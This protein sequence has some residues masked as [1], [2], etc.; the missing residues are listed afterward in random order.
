VSTPGAHGELTVFPTEL[1]RRRWQ[2]EQV[3]RDGWLDASRLQTQKWLRRVCLL[4]ARKAG[5]LDGMPCDAAQQLLMLRR[6]VVGART[7]FDAAGPLAALS[8]SALADVLDQLVKELSGLADRA[9]QVEEW[10]LGH[11]PRHK[12]YQLG[13]LYRVWRDTLNKNGLV[14]QRDLNS[15]ILQLLAG[16]RTQ[17]PPL[18]RDAGRIAF[19]SVRWLSPFDE[20]LVET[21]KQQL[22]PENVCIFSV[23][24]VA[25][26]EQLEGRLGA[27]IRSEIMGPVEDAW[28]I[29]VEDL[30]DALEVDSS[31]VLQADDAN[32]I[33]FSRSAGAYGEIEDLAR[34]ICFE[35]QTLEVPWNQIALVLPDIGNVQDIIPHVF[36]RFQIPYIFR[37]G[38][39]VLSAPCVK[40]FMSLLSWPLRNERDH[41]IDL[42]RNPA[43][44]WNFDDR[45]VA[46]Q[47]LI[48]SGAPPRLSPSHLPEELHAELTDFQPLET[49]NDRILVDEEDEL[50]REALKITEDALISMGELKLPRAEF[51]ALLEEL[52][53]DLTVHS[54][55]SDEQGVWIINPFDTAGLKFDT[56]LFAGLN[57]GTYPATPQ[58][59]ALISDNERY[60]LRKSL[61]EQG[62]HLPKLAMPQS[63]VQMV[64]QTVLFFSALGMARERLV[65]SCQSIDQEGSEKA[66]SAFYRKIWNLAGW[67][68]ERKMDLCAYDRW[69]IDL[70]GE[71]SV[72]SN[73][74]KKQQELDPEDRLPLPGE[75]FLPVVPLPLCRARDEAMQ[76]AVQ[77]GQ[78]TGRVVEMLAME[79]ERE[80]FLET[81]VDDRKRSVYCGQLDSLKKLVS[82]WIEQKK[83][84]SPT[85]LECLAQG[86]YVFL[87]EKM[88]GIRE[89]RSADELPDPLDRGSLLHNILCAIYSALTGNFQPLEK[90]G[91][92]VSS[93]WK[94]ICT[95]R[96]WAEKTSNGWNKV[97]GPGKNA[98]PLVSF[99]PESGNKVPLFGKAVT[100]AYC[101]FAERRGAK[102]GHSGVWA[103]EKQKLLVEVENVLRHDVENAWEENRFPALF[104][105]PFGIKHK[106]PV[107]LSGIF[108]KGRIDRVDLVFEGDEL[109]TVR[110][111]DYKGSSRARSKT[112]EYVDEVRRNLD[113]QLPIYAF[114][115][116]QFFFGESNT[117]PLNAMT[118]AGY[119]FRERDFKEFGR[120]QGRSLIPLDEEGMLK[121]FEETLKENLRRL[122]DTDF[123]VDPLIE[124]YN[125][126]QSIFRVQAIKR[127]D[128]D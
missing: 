108:L 10:M 128:L 101:T 98:I 1:A 9:E 74:W 63:D 102:L 62:A 107:E 16:E 20:Q 65:L 68:A 99:F 72:F 69:R 36:H 84:F 104:E 114:A 39:P 59:S 71:D 66:P 24:P 53:E 123:A 4:Y 115:A 15:A 29:W 103:A 92:E 13:V 34:R 51:L 50:N 57:D 70:L 77:E 79:A 116:Q 49:L 94:E 55:K 58:P 83:E 89:E 82:E 32:R 23:L 60:R 8:D 85:A 26:A 33:S 100:E 21:L 54:E 35:F 46:V 25:H 47:K 88:L 109:M 118:E 2:Q 27:R 41:L 125:D 127:E 5:L 87:L 76:A 113:C 119:I 56:V 110:V 95:P 19:R 14:D 30:G 106:L 64:Q 11:P 31:D 86:R 126:W 121:A 81:P 93:D 42:I 61:E 90:I 97:F 38:R 48:E 44:K 122:R 37:R 78:A 67:G 117:E 112:E 111:L 17:W 43:I 124:S 6:A 40:A 28:A 22:G 7:H 96:C 3:L 91:F 80:T 75:S 18:L 45:E 105:L 52:L 12:L 120:K 73:H